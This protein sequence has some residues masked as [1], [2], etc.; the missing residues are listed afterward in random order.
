[1]TA[2][3][4]DNYAIWFNHVSS[5]I[6]LKLSSL[7]SGQH[8]TLLINGS[9]TVWR[10]MRPGNGRPTSGISIVEGRNIWEKIPMQSEFDLEFS[11]ELSPFVANMCRST[12]LQPSARLQKK[13]LTKA[14]RS[15][16]VKKVRIADAYLFADYSGALDKRQQRRAI[17]VA[18][19]EGDNE[20]TCLDGP[21]TRETLRMEMLSYLATATSRGIRLFIGQDHQ[22]SIPFGLSQ[23][24]GIANLS[25]R[26]LL[27]DLINGTYATNA[28]SLDHAHSFASEFNK[29]LEA[30]GHAPYFWSATKPEY[31]LPKNNPR[32][33]Q[34]E[35]TIFRLTESFGS[36]YGTGNPMPFNR[37]GDNGS[38]GGQTL[39]G[40]RMIRTLLGE[41][42]RDGIPLR[43]WPFDGI[44]IL[45]PVY[46]NS[47]VMF[48]PY[49]SAARTLLTSQFDQKFSG[50]KD[51][52]D[53]IAALLTIRNADSDKVLP[54][55]LDLNSLS[56]EEQIIVRSEGWIVGHTPLKRRR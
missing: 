5:D 48:E 8:I 2:I 30:Q 12:Q 34:E 15:N 6:A 52:R 3:K 25:W 31:N 21:Y 47:H 9:D 19:A 39:V 27:D 37:V 38:V 29:W 46:E 26:Q 18:Y 41:C 53:A 32:S 54:Q 1:M 42:A 17:R 20:P 49:P 36:I 22:Y 44:D 16:D 28:P 45:D 56:A 33:S 23:E 13:P 40:L 50:S 11:D 24:L 14:V 55:L 4:R 35:T 43:C 7:E 10:R 51:A